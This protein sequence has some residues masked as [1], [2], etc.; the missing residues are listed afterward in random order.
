LGQAEEAALSR[1]FGGIHHRFDCD[2]GLVLGRT[3][4]AYALAHD[5]AGHEPFVLK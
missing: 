5:V 3:I 2:A 4:A 1:I